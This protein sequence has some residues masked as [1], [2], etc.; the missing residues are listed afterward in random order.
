MKTNVLLWCGVVGCLLV[1]APRSLRGENAGQTAED[2]TTTLE[3]DTRGP[4]VPYSRL[5]FGGFLEHF[6]RQIYGGVFEPG[7]PLADAQ[8]FRTDVV[9]A[10]RELRVPIVRWPGGCFASGYHWESGIGKHRLPTDDMAWGV[11]D[12]N[13][14]GTD[15]YVQL[16]RLL[17]WQPYICNNAGNGTVAEMKSWVEYCNTRQG[18]YADERAGNGHPQPWNVRVWS[19]GNE[20]WGAHEIGYKPI[21]QWSPLV[22]EAALAMKAADPGIQLSAAALPDRKWMLPMLA[23]AGE[24]LDYISLHSYALPLHGR[25]DM[26]DYLT[27]IMESEGPEKLIVGAVDILEESGHRGRIKIAYD[28][29][30]LRSW[31]HPGFPRQAVADASNPE[32]QALVEAR[33]NN[34]IASQYTMADALFSASF[35]NSCLRHAADVGMANIAP[36]VN[37]R[38][39]LH[40][41]SRGIVRRTH[42]HTMAI[43]A[44][45]LEPR[46]AATKV[47]AGPLVHGDRR[48]AAV[49]AVAT[50]DES[51]QNIAV[52]IV[53]RHPDRTVACRIGV[54]GRPLPDGRYAAI[55]LAGDS[56]EAFNDI[57][58]PDRVVPETTQI[59]CVRGTLTLPA[60]SL[61]IVKTAVT[62]R[63]R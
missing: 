18:R 42:F 41:H 63:P 33:E 10:L 29:W 6:G 19:I 38:G 50:V 7:S 40:V 59:D 30:N 58:H 8:G 12:P 32:V 48:V 45:E 14:F 47:G 2:G 16:C 36:L 51:G 28:E 55:V 35:Y 11:V 15:E 25:N 1:V 9:A 39:P 4:S 23:Q 26:P 61:T 31:H 43:Y 5:I 24:H 54:D 57:D 52:A 21:E 53:N 17:D 27:C 22:L 13:T 44:N 34:E 37:T 20:N 3:I 56:P 60:H 46:V 49:D 62:T